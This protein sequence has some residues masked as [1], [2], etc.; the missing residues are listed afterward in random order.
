[1]K[2]T[3][4]YENKLVQFGANKIQAAILH[5]QQYRSQEKRKNMQS[6]KEL[7]AKERYGKAIIDEETK[8]MSELEHVN[9]LEEIERDMLSR[10]KHTQVKE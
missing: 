2:R 6:M 9:K 8:N 3:E 1:M 5:D 10:L 4:I 7:E